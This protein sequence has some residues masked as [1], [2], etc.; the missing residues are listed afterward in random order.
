MTSWRC[1]ASLTTFSQDSAHIIALKMTFGCVSGNLSILYFILSFIIFQ[2][3]IWI[4][5]VP[6]RLKLFS[7]IVIMWIRS[8]LERGGYIESTGMTYG[9]PQ[10]SILGPLLFNLY[11]FPLFHILQHVRV[12]HHMWFPD[13]SRIITKWLWSIDLSCCLEE[14]NNWMP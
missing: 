2:C 5:L 6:E 3:S 1:M 13:L 10:G 11:M 14:G 12:P 8:Y 4:L 7:E 9:V